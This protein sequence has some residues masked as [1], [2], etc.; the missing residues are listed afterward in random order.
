MFSVINLD[1]ADDA[2]DFERAKPALC[3]FN[4]HTSVAVDFLDSPDSMVRRTVLAGR[5]A[6]HNLVVDIQGGE[7]F[8]SCG[9][10]SWHLVFSLFDLV[11]DCPP[12]GGC[13]F[14]A[15]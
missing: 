12:C 14:A 13:C 9:N 6:Q 10:L 8:G 1:R 4:R 11:K 15:D 7:T 5:I 3:N 2:V